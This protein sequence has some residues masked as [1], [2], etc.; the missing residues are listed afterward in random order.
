MENSLES[1]N[2][3]R[4]DTNSE[5]GGSSQDPLFLAIDS[6]SCDGWGT[7]SEKN[8]KNILMDLFVRLD[9][10]ETVL[11]DVTSILE[12]KGLVTKQDIHTIIKERT[13]NA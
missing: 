7:N 2:L 9:F 5:K 4:I 8:I 3:N 10:A 6:I 13:I 11:D 1:S 12:R